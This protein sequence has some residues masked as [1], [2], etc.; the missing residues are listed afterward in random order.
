ML[1]KKLLSELGPGEC[2][3]VEQER[4]ED[5]SGLVGSVLQAANAYCIRS[6]GTEFIAVTSAAGEERTFPPSATVAPIPR[7]GFD[8]LAAHYRRALEEL[9]DDD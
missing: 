7:G 9:G 1:R 3:V 4:T 5:R 6:I 2:F 8:R